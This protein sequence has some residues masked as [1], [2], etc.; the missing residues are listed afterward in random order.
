MGLLECVQQMFKLGINND[1][2]DFRKVKYVR[3]VVG[4]Q[5]V[6]NRDNDTARSNNSIY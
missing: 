2:I 4:L 5:P 6:V 3:N 1:E